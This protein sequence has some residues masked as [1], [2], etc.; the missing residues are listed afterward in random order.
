MKLA[1]IFNMMLVL[2]FRAGIDRVGTGLWD[3]P[4]RPVNCEI[5]NLINIRNCFLIKEIIH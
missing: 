1:I 4:G 3:S 5:Q 2:R